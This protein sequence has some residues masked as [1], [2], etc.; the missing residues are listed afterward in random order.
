MAGTLSRSMPAPC[1]GDV[2]IRISGRTTLCPSAAGGSN[3]ARSTKLP[4]CGKTSSGA[5]ALGVT[6]DQ[7]A[8]PG[9]YHSL[10]IVLRG[11]I[12]S[13]K[14]ARVLVLPI[15]VGRFGNV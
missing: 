8:R 13:L 1:S 14:V 11:S 6:F 10:A 5:S 15:L 3:A 2:V 7:R 12:V 4:A 9:A